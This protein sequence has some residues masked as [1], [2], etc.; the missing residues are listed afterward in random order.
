MYCIR[1]DGTCKAAFV[2]DSVISLLFREVV[3]VLGIILQAAHTCRMK[4]LL[5]RAL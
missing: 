4:E 2:S 1:K 3:Q 5:G